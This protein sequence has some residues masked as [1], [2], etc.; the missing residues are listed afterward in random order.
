M[1]ACVRVCVY[2][3]VLYCICQR[4]CVCVCVCSCVCSG[5]K[6]GV[7]VAP[8]PPPSKPRRA[9]KTPRRDVDSEEEEEEEEEE[10][11]P[12][13][14]GKRKAGKQAV[15]QGVAPGSYT[16]SFLLGGSAEVVTTA[17]VA[18]EEGA[19]PK[20]ASGG[21][22]AA[23]PHKPPARVS[24]KEEEAGTPATSKPRMRVLLSPPSLSTLNWSEFESAGPRTTTRVTFRSG[25]LLEAACTAVLPDSVLQT[26]LQRRSGKIV[27]PR[28][29]LSSVGLGEAAPVA[30]TPGKASRSRSRGKGDPNALHCVCQQ[31]EDPEAVYCL[32]ETC[33]GWFHP[34]CLGYTAE[35][36]RRRSECA[37][38]CVRVCA[39]AL[40]P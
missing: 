19:K 4:V 23:T 13:S 33:G 16:V 11:A 26:L 3:I 22:K 15:R 32:C 10:P 31:P 40:Q 36:V 8:S 24:V 20:A 12:P 39:R 35:E 28:K 2:C 7:V 25:D 30:K 5:G 27:L 38:V 9:V 17:I 1:R 18:A 14:T 29:S 6:S 34:E 21:G 37:C